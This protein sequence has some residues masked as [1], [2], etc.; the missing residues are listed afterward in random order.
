VNASDE[1]EDAGEALDALQAEFVLLDSQWEEMTHDPWHLKA[2][3]ADLNLV[4]PALRAAL[5]LVSG[6]VAGL[7]V[8]GPLLSIFL[9]VAA[10]PMLTALEKW[11]ARKA[12]ENP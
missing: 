2:I 12:A 4:D 9:G 10:A 3:A 1:E 7:P 5:P 11:L 6:L 8:A